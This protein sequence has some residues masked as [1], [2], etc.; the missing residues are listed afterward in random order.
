MRGQRVEHF[1][2][3]FGLQRVE[4]GDRVVAFE[5]AHRLGER[6]DRQLLEDLLARR[7]ADLGQRGEVE[8]LA[9][10]RDELLA[11]VVIEKLEQRAE[12]RLVQRADPGARRLGVT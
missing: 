5:I 1:R 9:H 6:L 3:L 10:Q 11:R 7:L 4:N 12:I 2:L 8:L